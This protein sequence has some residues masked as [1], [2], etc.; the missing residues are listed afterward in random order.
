M[1]PTAAVWI[2][3]AINVSVTVVGIFAAYVHIRERLVRMETQLEPLWR[4]YE[5]RRGPAGTTGQHP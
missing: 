1:T 4:A 2:G 3:L 5:R